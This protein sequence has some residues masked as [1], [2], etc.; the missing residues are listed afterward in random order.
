[1]LTMAGVREFGILKYR[2]PSP[3][4][5]PAWNRNLSEDDMQI[6]VL[7]FVIVINVTEVKLLISDFSQVIQ[8]TV[9]PHNVI[10]SY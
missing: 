9:K 2:M 5:K 6:S 3:A 8:N 1:M 10:H 4:L 7:T